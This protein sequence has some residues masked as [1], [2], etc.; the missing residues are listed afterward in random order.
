METPLNKKQRN[1]ATI[2]FILVCLVSL[3]FLLYHV[4]ISIEAY[5]A[6]YTAIGHSVQNIAPLNG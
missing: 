6:D 3:L 5:H 1:S 2:K 4:L